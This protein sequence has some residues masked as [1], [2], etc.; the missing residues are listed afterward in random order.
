MG[1]Q[2]PSQF[3]AAACQRHYHAS[4]RFT[5]NIVDSNVDSL[6]MR[7][8]NHVLLSNGKIRSQTPRGDWSLSFE[9][10]KVFDAGRDDKGDFLTLE[11]KC[12]LALNRIIREHVVWAGG[13]SAAKTV[14]CAR[15]KTI[16]S[17]ATAMPTGTT[18]KEI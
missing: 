4:G 6:K 7:D 5:A 1:N 12:N 2:D 10:D 13:R 14:A 9:L 16:S 11:D 8:K 3:L 15:L 17:R 18:R